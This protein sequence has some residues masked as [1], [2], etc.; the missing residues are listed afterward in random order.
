[1]TV[2]ADREIALAM[3]EFVVFAT[4]DGRL[5]RLEGPYS[6]PAAGR[7]AGAPASAS[8][9]RRALEQLFG[10]RPAEAGGL[11]GVRGDAEEGADAADSRPDPWWIHAERMGDL[12]VVDGERVRVWR[13]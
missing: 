2:D 11:A 12:C 7:D 4:E 9:V 8:N 5:V 10:L 6:G 13:E 3:D 1:E